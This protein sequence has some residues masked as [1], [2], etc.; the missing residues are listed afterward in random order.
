MPLLMQNLNDRKRMGM[1]A[2]RL[3]KR[4]QIQQM[5]KEAYGT[6]KYD[7]WTKAPVSNIYTTLKTVWCYVMETRADDFVEA[8]RK[9]NQAEDSP[10]HKIMVRWESIKNLNVA[11]AS[12]FDESYDTLIDIMP[13]KSD[14]YL[15]LE[16]DGKS[17]KGRR[18]KI[19]N[20]ALDEMNSEYVLIRA[21]QIEEV[22][23]GGKI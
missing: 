2:P 8:I 13:L 5:D 11:F 22:G 7:Q 9:M 19:N 1:I 15:F 6:D 21:T 16:K 12:S 18:L 20:I 10:T 14:Y 17:Y 23:T 3:N 4:V